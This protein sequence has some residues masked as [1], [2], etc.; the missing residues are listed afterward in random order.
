MQHRQSRATLERR[1]DRGR[2]CVANTGIEMGGTC[3]N[4]LKGGILEDL[5]A[6]LAL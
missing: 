2:G 6:V 1:F 4:R 3:N 5:R